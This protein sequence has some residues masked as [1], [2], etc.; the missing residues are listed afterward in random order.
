MA[1]NAFNDHFINYKTMSGI[2]LHWKNLVINLKATQINELL[3]IKYLTLNW[4]NTNKL[5]LK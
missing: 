1:V 5:S 2:R 3:N 4:D